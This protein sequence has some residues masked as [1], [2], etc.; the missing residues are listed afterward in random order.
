MHLLLSLGFVLY[1]KAQKRYQRRRSNDP[2]YSILV[3]SLHECFIAAY[4]GRFSC[5]Q[6]VFSLLSFPMT[7]ILAG[8]SG[9][10]ND[11]ASGSNGGSGGK[12]WSA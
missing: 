9:C 5:T 6:S 7:I 1:V 11:P 10:L 8:V 4:S 3:A 2:N 12:F